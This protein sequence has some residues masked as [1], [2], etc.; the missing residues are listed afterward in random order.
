MRNKLINK[1]SK[2]NN[3]YIKKA[4]RTTI[5]KHQKAIINMKN[6]QTQVFHVVMTSNEVKIKFKF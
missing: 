3:I 4:T 2:N 5:R 6:K 1:L